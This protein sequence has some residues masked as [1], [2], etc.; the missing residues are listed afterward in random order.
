MLLKPCC[1]KPFLVE[2]IGSIRW[3][4]D[5]TYNKQTLCSRLVISEIDNTNRNRTLRIRLD[6]IVI[7]YNNIIVRK[8]SAIYTCFNILTLC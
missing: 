6:L 4:L 7:I 5:F 1:L 3:E 8:I 2:T